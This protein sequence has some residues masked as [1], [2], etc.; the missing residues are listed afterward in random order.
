VKARRGIG[1]GI[2]TESLERKIEGIKGVE[3]E[4]EGMHYG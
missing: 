3:K 4:V 2:G 1:I